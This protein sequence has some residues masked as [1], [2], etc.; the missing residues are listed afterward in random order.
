MKTLT[1]VIVALAL[2]VTAC[3]DSMVVDNHLYR[4][5]GLIDRGTVMDPRIDYN[6]SWGNVF[7]GI[8]L[9]ETIIAPIYFFGFALFEPTGSKDQVK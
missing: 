7:W 6:V 3:A 8:L 4:P 1:S 2:T 5:Y 9:S